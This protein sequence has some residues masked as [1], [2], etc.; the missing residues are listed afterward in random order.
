MFGKKDKYA[1][2]DKE[3]CSKIEAS[4]AQAEEKTSGEIRVHVVERC[5]EN[6][7]E[8]AAMAFDSLGMAKTKLRNGVLLFFAT[9][10][11]K[12]AI[13]GDQG[14]NDIVGQGFWDDAVEMVERGFGSGKPIEAVCDAIRLCG[15][16]LSAHFPPQENDEDDLPNQ[17]SFQK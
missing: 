3:A 10:D 5:R 15:E 17:V 7:L 4:I 6:V 16:K 9:Q 8:S 11:R 1:P 2:F 12:F 13:I 14:I